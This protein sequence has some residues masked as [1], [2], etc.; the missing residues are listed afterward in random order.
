MN[1]NKYKSLLL[2]LIIVA[3]FNNTIIFAQAVQ[4]TTTANG[5]DKF[6]QTSLITTTLSPTDASIAT[7]QMDASK[8]FQKMEGFGFALNGGSAALIDQ[9]PSVKKQ[10]LLKEIFGKG[11]DDLGVNYIRISIGASDLDAHVFSYDDL[12]KGETDSLLLKFSLSPSS[13]P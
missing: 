10:A 13:P 9:L 2:L 6:K 11:K 1:S 3:L 5:L 4:Y 7:I 12:P 8:G